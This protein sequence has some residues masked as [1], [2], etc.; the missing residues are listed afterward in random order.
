[1]AVKIRKCDAGTDYAEALTALDKVGPAN[2]TDGQNMAGFC[3][4]IMPLMVGGGFSSRLVWEGAQK[5]GLTTLQLHEI[6]HRKDFDA[7]DDLQFP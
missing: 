5:A 1:M 2:A 7:L 3:E 6:C 4:S